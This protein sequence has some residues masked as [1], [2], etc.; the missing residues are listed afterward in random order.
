MQ[1]SLKIDSNCDIYR[2]VSPNYQGTFEFNVAKNGGK[3]NY[4]M[5][6][7]TYKPYTPMIK[8]APDFS[9]LYGANYS[10][11]RGLICGGDFSLPRATSAWETYQLNNKNKAAKKLIPATVTPNR[12]TKV[13][14]SQTQSQICGLKN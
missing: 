12:V 3:V 1:H 4:F 11:N 14:S 8:V 5:A 2:I 7:C 10:D 13:A 9:L 6:Q